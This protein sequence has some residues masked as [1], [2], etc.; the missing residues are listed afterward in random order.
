M[1]IHRREPLFSRIKKAWMNTF[2]YEMN[3]CL[4]KYWETYGTNK[5][6][7]DP[8]SHR[9][10]LQI[11]NPIGCNLSPTRMTY[12]WHQPEDGT[13]VG[14]D[15]CRLDRAH[16]RWWRRGRHWPV[17]STPIP[18]GTAHKRRPSVV[19][20]PR[21]VKNFASDLSEWNRKM[22]KSLPCGTINVS[23]NN[24]FINFGTNISDVTQ[25]AVV[26]INLYSGD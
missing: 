7:E 3:G 11:R 13:E 5:F 10:R 17:R 1:N 9:A 21:A 16:N 26:K 25:L 24:I 22:E 12:Q 6:W 8:G 19:P 20:Q 23:P 18:G 14:R 2:W 4:R 15:T